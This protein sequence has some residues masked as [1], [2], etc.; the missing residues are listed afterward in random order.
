LR[1]RDILNQAAQPATGAS[2]AFTILV[3]NARKPLN[4]GSQG[5]R[6]ETSA[7]PRRDLARRA[8]PE[9]ESDAWQ[10]RIFSRNILFLLVLALIVTSA[11][12]WWASAGQFVTQQV[13]ATN[14]T[15]LDARASI[16]AAYAG[17]EQSDVGH[18]AQAASTVTSGGNILTYPSSSAVAFGQSGE[19]ERPKY[20]DLSG[21]S[22][23]DDAREQRLCETF[24]ELEATRDSA[25]TV[26]SCWFSHRFLFGCNA[27]VTMG[28]RQPPSLVDFR[29]ENVAVER[30][31]EVLSVLSN[32]ILPTLYGFLGAFVAVARNIR[33]K[34]KESLLT[35][36]DRPQMWA[37]MLLGAVIGACIG[38]FF[39]PSSASGSASPISNVTFTSSGLSFLAGFGADEAF[40]WI[41]N[42][43]KALF[44]TANSSPS[45]S[46][47]RTS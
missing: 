1:A 42:L 9:Y 38:L 35:P 7:M 31:G 43:V 41:N 13:A 40:A 15:A 12:S 5:K 3:A 10:F 44:G 32:N 11:L 26:V 17:L 27:G 30:A 16:Y 25:I 36:R 4:Y 21:L 37:Q 47:T 29:S 22:P 2:I 14:A 20:C 33:L 23:A 18:A 45:V 8:Y 24:D 19:W 6:N 34:T 39:S 46:N 28:G